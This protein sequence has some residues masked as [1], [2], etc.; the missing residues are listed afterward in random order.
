M[1]RIAKDCGEMR[2]TDIRVII[3]G[4]EESHIPLPWHRSRLRTQLLAMH[5]PPRQPQRRFRRALTARR[6]L[7]YSAVTTSV[8]IF[9][10]SILLAHPIATDNRARQ[11]V[12]AAADT[13]QH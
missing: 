3:D 12:M 10:F 4:L 7:Q 9:S 2:D 13:V 6:L 5:K 8:G 11:L 1:E